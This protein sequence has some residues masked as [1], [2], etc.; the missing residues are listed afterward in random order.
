MRSIW[1]WALLYFL[2]YI[3]YGAL[4]KAISAGALPGQ[5][6]PVPG[7]ALL[8]ASALASFGVMV[9]FLAGTGWW[10]RAHR[11]RVAGHGLP[12]PTWATFASGA[13]TAVILATS[14]LAYT[15]EGVSIVFVMLLMR[16]GVLAMA[17]VVDLW[18][19][20][21]PRPAAWVGLGLSALAVLVAVGDPRAV[22]AVHLSGAA[23]LNIAVYLAA[24][25][26]RLR[27]MSREA[28]SG[29][30]TATVRY[31]VEEQ[32]VVAPLTLVMLVAFAAIGHGEMMQAVRAGFGLLGEPGLAGPLLAVGVFSQLVGIFGTLIF[33]DPRENTFSVSVNRASSVLSGV[34]ATA[35]LWGLLGMEAPRGPELAGAGLV[36]LAIGVLGWQARRR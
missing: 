5:A 21:R 19:R 27:V 23:V 12:A 13:C 24:Y 17:P 11:V 33:L 36:T 8:P 29:D 28:K 3:P 6:G 7:P 2:C 16:G 35:A 22:G 26:V 15:F 14:T 30:D 4:S 10:R 34:V 25:A 31:F 32:L 18:S 9:A 20:R 1:V